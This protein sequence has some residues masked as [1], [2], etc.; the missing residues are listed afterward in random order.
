VHIV[1]NRREQAEL[2]ENPLAFRKLSR[3]RD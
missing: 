2:L 3:D 1:K